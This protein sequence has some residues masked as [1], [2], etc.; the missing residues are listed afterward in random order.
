M[1]QPVN[2]VIEHKPSAFDLML[3][4]ST[5]QDLDKL[6]ETLANSGM[7][8]TIYAGKP[9]MIA[10]AATMGHRLGVDIFSALAGIAVINGR[11]AVW[12]DLM[13]AVCQKD[14]SWEDMEE[15]FDDKTKTATCTVTRKGRKPYVS[16]FSFADAQTASLIGKQGPWTTNPKRMCGMRARAFAL[17]G[18]YA[19]I[20]AGF[21]TREEMEDA[22]LVEVQ[23]TVVPEAKPAR[24][25]TIKEPTKAE[26]IAEQILDKA[27]EAA[28]AMEQVKQEEPVVVTDVDSPTPTVADYQIMWKNVAQ[29]YPDTYL[30]ELKA[31][32]AHFGVKKAGEIKPEQVNEAISLLIKVTERLEK[33]KTGGAQ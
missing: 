2:T 33:A 31:M 24:T 15:S 6:C 14:K 3:S 29:E 5:L 26:A 28:V 18:V 7:V 12:G 20:L 10:V 1:N 11:P 27:V 17:R 25:R 13:L 23:G 22:D 32:N 9:K 19:D 4:P 30:A 21:V 8:P 16:T